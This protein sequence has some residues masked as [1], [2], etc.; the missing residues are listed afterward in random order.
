MAMSAPSLAMH[1]TMPAPDPLGAPRHDGHLAGQSHGN[2]SRWTQA[3]TTDYADYTD[4]IP[5][6]PDLESVRP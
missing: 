5:D 3:S 6:F 2:P 4:S 1:S